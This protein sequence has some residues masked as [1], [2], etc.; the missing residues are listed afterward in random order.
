LL[1]LLSVRAIAQ[2]RPEPQTLGAVVVVAERAATPL[3]LTTAA[4]T[5]LTSDDLARLPFTTIADVLKRVPGFAVVDFDGNGRDPQLMVRGFYGGGEAEYVQVLVDG[6]P[7]NLAHN[8]TINWDVLPPLSSIAS[9]EIVRGSA[10][11]LHG[12]AAVAGVIN[13]ITRRSPSASGGWRLGGESFAGLS[14]SAYIASG[15]RDRE[16]SF[17]AGFDRTD[18][19]RDHAERSSATTG[20]TVRLTPQLKAIARG[21]WRDFDEPGPLLESLVHDGSESDPR[22]ADDGGKDRSLSLGLDHTGSLG[23]SGTL[24]TTIRFDMR[25]ADLTRT[26]PL[27]PDFGDTRDRELRTGQLDLAMQA[28]FTPTILPAGVDRVTLGASADFGA[29]DSRY[30]STSDIGILSEHSRGD[31]YRQALSGFAHL[32]ARAGDWLRWTLGA[33]VDYLRDAFE[34][35]TF[36]GEAEF[37]EKNSHFAFSPKIGLNVRYAPSGRAWVSASRTFKA[38]THDQQFDRRPIPIPFPPGEITTSNPDLEPQRGTSADAG[39]YHDFTVSSARL[40]VTVTLYEIAMRN[41]LDFDVQTF[42]Y[43]NIARSRHRGL[44]AGLTLTQGIVS[45]NA[46]VTLQDVIS[47]A[48]AH[49]GK[50]LKAVPGQL[51]SAGASLS[52][53]GVGTFSLDVTRTADVFIDDANTR[54][55][56]AWTRVDAQVSRPVGSLAIVVGAR[57]LFGERYNTTGFL[58]PAG[59]GQA[60]YYP[61]AGRVLTLGIRHGR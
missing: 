49:E 15:F 1:A 8:G 9:I 13:I 56:P 43:V 30:F 55:F 20:A 47:R 61:A 29:I 12:D 46:A 44:E 60:Y 54:R 19:Y 26:L 10:S 27:S 40:G 7:V 37:N 14:A 6:R 42:K 45:A 58:D 31:G 22:F 11:A 4:V 21:T 39:V 53:A 23:P 59:S 52:P 24:N 18:G 50:Q 33:R 25:R 28:D 2:D 16:L 36:P 51:L 35:E 48:G 32:A 17:S 38:P 34:E 5:R 3:N 57:N 41:E